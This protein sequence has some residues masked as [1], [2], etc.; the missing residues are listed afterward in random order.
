MVGAAAA[1]AK[2]TAAGAM[3]AV[4]GR[5]DDGPSATQLVAAG[6]NRLFT[7]DVTRECQCEAASFTVAYLLG[8]PVFSLT[9]NALEAIKL[10]KD[11]EVGVTYQTANGVS[12]LLV[13]LLAAVAIESNNHRQLIVSDPRQASALLKLLRKSAGEDEAGN[14][15]EDDE[16]RLRL[17]LSQAQDLLQKYPDALEQLSQR[18]E[19][20]AGTVGNCVAILEK[21]VR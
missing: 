21:P 15:A 8:I 7:R 20:G 18:M 17:A 3:D 2:E 10:T 19:S 5:D 14:T 4:R 9:P 1:A 11:A 13:W 16:L 6:L 12:K